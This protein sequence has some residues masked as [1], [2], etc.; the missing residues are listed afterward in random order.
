[1][2]EEKEGK[3]T[4]NKIETSKKKNKRSNLPAT[5]T[6]DHLG[7]ACPHAFLHTYKFPWN[8]L[9]I[10]FF[11]LKCIKYLCIFLLLLSLVNNLVY[12]SLDHEVGLSKAGLS[13]GDCEGWGWSR[14]TQHTG[15]QSDRVRRRRGHGERHWQSHVKCQKP[16]GWG[17]RQHEW[18]PDDAQRPL[19]GSWSLGRVR[20]ASARGWGSRGDGRLITLEKVNKIT[21]PNIGDGEHQ[22]SPTMLMRI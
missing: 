18:Q 22:H 10:K 3:K 12:G 11:H 5:A 14:S 16:S 1:M 9:F 20:R 15:Y 2:E 7:I 8:I 13:V 21:I 6:V 19:P 17:G 4:K